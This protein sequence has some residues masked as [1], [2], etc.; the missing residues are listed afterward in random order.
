MCPRD[1]VDMAMKLPMIPRW[2]NFSLRILI[3]QIEN[4]CCGRAMTA[5]RISGGAS[6]WHQ[7]MNDSWIVQNMD[8]LLVDLN[9][10]SVEILDGLLRV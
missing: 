8:S 7:T 10:N 1:V 5:A 9:V 6:T 2:K 4:Y 3:I